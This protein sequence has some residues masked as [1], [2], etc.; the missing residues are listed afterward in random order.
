MKMGRDTKGY[1]PIRGAS[2]GISPEAA[3]IIDDV[4]LA[5]ER[6]PADA[7][8]A[9][10]RLVALLT[11]P[12]EP[13]PV[14][15]R[16]GLAK[17]QKRKVEQYLT[18]NLDRPMY[19]AQ[20]AKLVSLSAGH[21]SR[22]FKQTFGLT[23]HEHIIQQRLEWAQQ[24]MLSTED[25]LSQ[26]ALSCGMAD[27]SHLTRLFRRGVGETP[28]AWRRRSITDAEVGSN[29]AVVTVRRAA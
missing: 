2:A 23:P 26:I 6:N 17:W 14:W 3:G 12:T 16:G 1:A 24:L 21:F 8:A 4:I 27:Q 25:S 5:L 18:E 10:L 28:G 9:A 13:D 11:R 29:V 7:R 22:A 20:L 19:V 15:T